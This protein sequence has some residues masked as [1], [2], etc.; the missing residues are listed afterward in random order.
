MERAD[1][2]HPD[3]ILLRPRIFADRRGFFFESYNQRIMTE[4]GITEAFV[5]DNHS[6][7]LRGVLRGMHYQMGRP[8]AKLVRVVRG[9]VLDVAVDIRRGSP[10]FGRWTGV[11]LS[12]D[13]HL[14]LYV[15][16]GFAHGFLVL[17]EEAEFE[18]KCSDFYAPAEERGLA[19]DDPDV[20]IDWPLDGAEPLLSE[21]DLRWP[22][23]AA[24]DPGQLPEYQP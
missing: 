11:E 10:H 18:Y 4:L 12:A 7:S 17:S 22:T 1:T 23:L 13:N 6:H 9:C 16:R 5:Q 20:D 19:W 15:P 14:I 8:Q 24:I 3:V 21:R 2:T